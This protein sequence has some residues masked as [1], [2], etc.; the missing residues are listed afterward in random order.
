MSPRTQVAR[1]EAGTV[2]VELLIAFP[3]VFLLFLGALQLALMYAADLVVHHAAW[4]AARSA[5]VVLDDDPK[6]Y[7]NEAPRCI[8]ESGGDSSVVSGLTTTLGSYF[9]AGASGGSSSAADSGSTHSGRRLAAIQHAA[10]LPLSALS[11]DPFPLSLLSTSSVAAVTFPASP[12]AD[13]LQTKQVALGNELT[14]RVTYLFTCAIPV[15]SALLCD[16][17]IQRRISQLTAKLGFGKPDRSFEQGQKELAHAPF[18]L[19]QALLWAKGTR[20][21]M[22]RAEAT[23]PTQWLPYPIPADN[24]CN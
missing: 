21:R 20:V 13:E 4:A 19:G 7:A 15:V 9:P 6:R 14:V 24:P 2:T 8:T 1:C 16:S 3:P 12:G 17:L 18:A 22:L 23:L 10:L 11:S 5:V